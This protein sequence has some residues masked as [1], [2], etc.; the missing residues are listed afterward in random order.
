MDIEGA[1][2]YGT[3]IRA[4]S[5]TVQITIGEA[6]AL[7]LGHMAT[8]VT[9]ESMHMNHDA[10][11]LQVLWRCQT[12]RTNDPSIGPG[13]PSDGRLDVLLDWACTTLKAQCALCT[14]CSAQ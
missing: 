1:T 8:G 14:V 2:A 10:C 11:W 5:K 13:R 3:Q 4:K 6:M 7:G 12:K 9:N